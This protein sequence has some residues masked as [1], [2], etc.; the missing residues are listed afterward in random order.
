MAVLLRKR[1][2]ATKQPALQRWL[3]KFDDDRAASGAEFDADSGPHFNVDIRQPDNSAEAGGD[4]RGREQRRKHKKA[5]KKKKERQ[6]S[7]EN[8]RGDNRNDDN[9]DTPN[10][11]NGRQLPALRGA[12]PKSALDGVGVDAS[13]RGLPSIHIN[14]RTGTA[15]A[16][17]SNNANALPSI[18]AKPARNVG[19]NSG[20]SGP[21]PS[22]H[23]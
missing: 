17:Y 3:E 8:D 19:G 20:L 16:T 23:R 10:V 18:Y 4:Q 2:E 12:R 6:R 1:K 13:A 22:L 14:P 7:L 11:T 5:K 15:P 9:P 21:L